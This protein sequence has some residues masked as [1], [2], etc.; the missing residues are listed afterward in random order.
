MCQAL[1]IDA[2]KEEED[3]VTLGMYNTSFWYWMKYNNSYRWFFFCFAL[4][5]YLGGGCEDRLI[6]QEKGLFQ[7]STAERECADE[8]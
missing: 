5:A 4:H 1:Q 7:N 8:S 6:K 2:R 3:S